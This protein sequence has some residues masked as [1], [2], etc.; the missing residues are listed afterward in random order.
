MI[1]YPRFEDTNGAAVATQWNVTFEDTSGAAAAAQRKVEKEAFNTSSW[2]SKELSNKRK[3]IYL[4]RG[5]HSKYNSISD[6]TTPPKK[7]K[8]T[9]KN[10]S[11]GYYVCVKEDLRPGMQSHGGTGYVM[12]FIGNISLI[13]FTISYE[14]CSSSGGWSLILLIGGLQ[15]WN[16]LF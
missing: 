15:S 2:A 4:E 14:K 9:I 3:C 16:V 5:T 1:K 6:L 10:I 8:L 7:N 12:E 11:P 13:T